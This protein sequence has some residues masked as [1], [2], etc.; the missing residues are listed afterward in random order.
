[1][2]NWGWERQRIGIVWIDLSGLKCLIARWA[3]SAQ[4]RFAPWNGAPTAAL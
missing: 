2:A 3:I 4:A 1:M